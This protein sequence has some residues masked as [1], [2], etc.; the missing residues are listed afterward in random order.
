MTGACL[1]FVT[2]VRAALAAAADP[3]KAAPMQAYMKSAMPFLGVPKPARTA[4]LRPVFRSHVLP[5]RESWEATVRLLW[6]RAEFREERY[7]ATDLA[8]HR[9]YAAWSTDPRSID[10]DDHLVVTGAWWDHVDEVAI[11]LVGPLLRAHPV[12][13]DR[14]VRRWS[15]DG[16]RW[17]RRAAVICQVGSRD[18]TDTALLADCIMAN[19]DDPDFFLRKGI[20]WALREHAKTDPDW[21]RAFVA[22]YRGR[23]SPLST[24]E[25][26]RT[27]PPHHDARVP[28]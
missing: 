12:R 18:A 16:D 7:A 4:A 2:D 5:D 9:N 28:E 20:G 1:P 11:R 24:R 15:R 17:R 25:A 21:V 23:L 27:L 22:T 19:A 10:L 13:I 3:A 6:D 26:T 8:R 14:V